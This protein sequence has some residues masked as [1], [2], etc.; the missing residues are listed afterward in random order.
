MVDDAHIDAARSRLVDL[1]G[2]AARTHAAEQRILERAE[3]RHAEVVQEL[4]RLRPRAVADRGAGDEYQ[5]LLVERGQ[6]EVI[7]A[8]S[9]EASA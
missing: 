5:R 6:L 2:L 9:R 1:T 3:A 4:D 8:K 7:I